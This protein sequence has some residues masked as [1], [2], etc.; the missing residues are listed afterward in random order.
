MEVGGKKRLFFE[1]NEREMVG[2]SCF[3]YSR[4]SFG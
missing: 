4:F 1:E 3:S 2:W